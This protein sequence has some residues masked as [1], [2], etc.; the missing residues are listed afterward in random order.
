MNYW[1]TIFSLAA[2]GLASP[3]CVAA[4]ESAKVD[5][6]STPAI[7]SMLLSLL[8]VVALILLLAWLFRRFNV[9]ATGSGVIKVLASVPVGRSERLL[10]VEIGGEQLLLGVTAHGISKLHR[11]EHPIDPQ[12]LNTGLELSGFAGKLEQFMKRSKHDR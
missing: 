4:S 1:R 2:L 7:A 5:T 8:T 6:L 11:L 3:V 10:L 12:S 9:G